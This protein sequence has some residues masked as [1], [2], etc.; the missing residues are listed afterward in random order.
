MSSEAHDVAAANDA[1]AARYGT[2][3]DAAV[4]WYGTG[5]TYDVADVA[6]CQQ[7]VLGAAVEHGRTTARNASRLATYDVG[8]AWHAAAIA[9]A[10]AGAI[11]I[12]R[13]AVEM[14]LLFKS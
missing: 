13:P 7:H 1:T 10:T 4:A 14:N 12:L 2:T 6:G 8:T 9:A 5:T 11:W 3:Y